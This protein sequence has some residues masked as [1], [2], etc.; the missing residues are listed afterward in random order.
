MEVV[1]W[2]SGRSMRGKPAPPA[3]GLW[4]PTPLAFLSHSVFLGLLVSKPGDKLVSGRPVVQYSSIFFF[5]TSYVIPKPTLRLEI[6]C[7]STRTRS[8]A[9][10]SAQRSVRHPGSN[11]TRLLETA[12]PVTFTIEL[13]ASNNHV[14]SSSITNSNHQNEYLVKRLI[15]SRVNTWTS[16]FH[17]ISSV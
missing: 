12:T 3:P 11:Q 13:G 8:S 17:S 5:G 14:K 10:K 2:P 15:Y 1:Q 16:R 7:R 6:Q 9:Q 4:P